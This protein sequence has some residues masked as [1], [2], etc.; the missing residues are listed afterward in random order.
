MVP[1]RRRL[2][3]DIAF[4]PLLRL[5]LIQRSAEADR[6]IK[7]LLA[8][9]PAHASHVGGCRAP[10]ERWIAA[11]KTGSARWSMSSEAVSEIRK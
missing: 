10:P 7:A 4:I 6:W 11:A 5:A 3:S 1:A 2:A 8:W 9:T